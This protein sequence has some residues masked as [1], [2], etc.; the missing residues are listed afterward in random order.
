MAGSGVGGSSGLLWPRALA[1]GRLG[2]N[3]SFHRAVPGVSTPQGSAEEAE[4]QV[5]STPGS[6][7]PEPPEAQPG[8]ELHY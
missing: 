1:L 4:G 7:G 8:S 5:T 2:L 6:P 3:Y